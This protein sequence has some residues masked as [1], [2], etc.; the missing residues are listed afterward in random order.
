MKIRRY[1]IEQCNFKEQYS[2]QK[3]QFSKRINA[4]LPIEGKIYI[5]NNCSI[6]GSSMIFFS[7]TRH[8][9]R[10]IQHNLVI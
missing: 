2:H 10:H 6:A 3:N 7:Y 9:V 8:V 5:R 1:L 4:I